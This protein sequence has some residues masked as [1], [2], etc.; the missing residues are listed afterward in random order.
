MENYVKGGNALGNIDSMV[1]GD[2]K[3][4]CGNDG[5]IV[6]NI[7]KGQRLR[8]GEANHSRKSKGTVGNQLGYSG[9]NMLE[10]PLNDNRCAY[11]SQNNGPQ[12]CVKNNLEIRV[13]DG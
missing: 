8:S 7:N 4:V 9:V 6:N 1:N 3:N 10:G 12:C 13:E 5:S 2:I 11:A